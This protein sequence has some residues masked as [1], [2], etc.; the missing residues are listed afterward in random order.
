MALE[1]EADPTFTPGTLTLLIEREIIGTRNSACS[2]RP[3]P[4]RRC[5]RADN[6]RVVEVG[7]D[8]GCDRRGRLRL[9]GEVHAADEVSVAGVGTEGIIDPPDA[10]G[11]WSAI[12]RAVPDAVV[13]A[14]TA[15]SRV[16]LSWRIISTAPSAVLGMAAD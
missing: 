2:S 15:V 4:V 6:A 3:L 16:I 1:F 11:R 7:E 14:F 5:A 9:L 12:G 13:R 10:S 8:L